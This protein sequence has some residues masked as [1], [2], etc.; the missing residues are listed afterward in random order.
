MSHSRLAPYVVNVMAAAALLAGCSNGGS[1]SPALN[2]TGMSPAQT[3][4]LNRITLPDGTIPSLGTKP[5]FASS[6]HPSQEK[7]WISPDVGRA[8]RLLFISDLGKGTVTIFTMPGLAVKGQIT[9]LTEPEGE[10]SDVS[11][12]VWVAVVG[13]QEVMELSRTGKMIGSVSTSPYGYPKS[14]AVDPKTGNLAVALHLSTR[15]GPGRVLVYKGGSG[16]P[17]SYRN[18][19][20]GTYYFPAYNDRGDLFVDGCLAYPCGPGEYMLSEL[21]ARGRIMHFVKITGGKIYFPGNLIWSNKN[22]YM[23]AFDQDCGDTHAACAYTLSISGSKGIITGSTGNFLDSKGNQICD[24]IEG[25]IG[26]NGEKLAA[27]GDYNDCNTS[28]ASAVYRWP[29][30]AGG[31]PTNS[32]TSSSNLGEPFGAALSTKSVVT[33]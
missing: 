20:Q 31:I 21:P 14:C 27:G 7:S 25:T 3:D 28:A 1:Q 15:F 10:C 23:Y 4:A 33:R 8:P 18:F 9:G 26:A 32:Y 17:T 13:S 11:G 24:M 29:N 30:P 22:H 2:P 5:V 12:H 19:F 16:S 6:I